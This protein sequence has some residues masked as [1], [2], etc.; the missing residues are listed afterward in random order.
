MIYAVGFCRWIYGF[1]LGFFDPT[2]PGPNSYKPTQ[3]CNPT[4]PVAYQYKKRNRK[5]LAH[6]SLSQRT[7]WFQ[8]QQLWYLHLRNPNDVLYHFSHSRLRV[9]FLLL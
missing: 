6:L 9:F 4:F 7:F 3:F 2:D 5:T 8:Q 1:Y